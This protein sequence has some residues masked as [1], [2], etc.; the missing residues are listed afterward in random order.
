MTDGSMRD[1]ITRAEREALI[2]GDRADALTLEERADLALMADLLA[3]PGTWAEPSA[4]FEDAVARAVARAEPEVVSLRD[5]A[6]RR[7]RVTASVGAAAASV[8]I[9]VG[10]LVTTVGGGG[11]DYTA[12][13]AATALAPGASASASIH[14]N[15]AGFRVALD[16]K[17]LPVLAD[18]EYYEAWLKN[19]SGALV[20]I[21]TFSSSNGRVTLWS[22]VSPAE[23]SGMS[24]TIEKPDNDQ[25]SSGHKVL[26]GT[27]NP[28]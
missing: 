25:N 7:R 16:P 23:F 26:V 20:P 5:R 8:A 27:V 19:A 22:G 28:G 21:G 13:L 11:A 2:A 15:A 9:V 12:R 4:G 17:G 3:D 24:V 6:S 14:H 18:G 10:V 1:G